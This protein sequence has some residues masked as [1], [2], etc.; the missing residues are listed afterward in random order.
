MILITFSHP[1]DDRQLE[2]AQNLTG[3]VFEKVLEI[4]THF[5]HSAIFSDQMAKLINDIPLDSM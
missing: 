1:L 2:I 3:C 5:D 4:K